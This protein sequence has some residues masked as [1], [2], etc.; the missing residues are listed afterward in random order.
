MLATGREALDRGDWI[1]AEAAF[2]AAIASGAGGG[3]YE[4][5][6]LALFWQSRIGDALRA[7]ERAYAEFRR[8]GDPGR[9]AWAALWIAGQYVRVHGNQA[10]AGGWAARC[11]R[12][13]AEAEPCAEVGRVILVRAL[14]SNDWEQI[15]RAAGQAIEIAKRFGDTDYEVLAVAYCGL[16]MLSTGRLRAGMA[17][18]DEAMAAATAGEV[19]AP[20]AVGQI[21]C[22]LL[23]G[24]ERT[25]D[26]ERAAQ[27]SQVAQPYLAAF[28][29]IGVT[30]TCRAIY[31]AVLTA[32]GRWPEAER[33]LQLALQTFEAGSRAMR[34]DALVRLADLRV[35]Q[36]RIDEAAGLLE[37]HEGHPDAQRPLAE[38]E[39][40]RGR[41]NVAVALLERRIRQLGVAG[42]QAAPLLVC[43]VEAH[44]A[45]GD[46]SAA[47]A[48]ADDLARLSEGYG[49]SVRGLARLAAGLCT[50]AGDG[51]AV[52]DLEIAL[53][54]LERAG[55]PWEAAR[56]RLAIAESV[57]DRNPQFAVREAGLARTGFAAI[58]A[59]PGADRAAAVLRRLGVR[60]AGGART[61]AALSRREEEVARMV[62]L[63]MSNDQIAARL[64]LSQRTVESHVSSVLRKLGMT[65]RVEIA[66]YA[67]RRLAG[68]GQTPREM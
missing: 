27:W 4:G 48:T 67:A 62:G 10:A 47:R 23:T 28:D 13:L 38:L 34:V 15:E 46:P 66:A 21:Y 55:M 60:Q 39:L 65:S 54:L 32:G 68:E 53:D 20:E 61:G 33:E 45:A 30:G 9:A 58:G 51:D 29:R 11:E 42:V 8:E 26:L 22:A 37:G 49:G 52:P 44:I 18:L 1:A 41:P 5:L 57:G 64:F 40:A 17:L 24:C 36:G 19:R 35:R 31:A 56:A 14:A 63:G 59:Q 12:L 50:A 25:V 7:M 16:A 43:L 3:A 6:C 2:E